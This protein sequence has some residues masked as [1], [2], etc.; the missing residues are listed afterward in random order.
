MSDET[1]V[2]IRRPGRIL[3]HDPQDEG[4]PLAVTVV[5]AV[6]RAIGGSLL[7]AMVVALVGWYLAD[8]GAHGQATGALRIGADGWLLGHG[9]T[10]SAG[11]VPLGI[12]P[13]GLAALILAF[14]HR[15][16]RRA[17]STLSYVPDDRR[18]GSALAA[19]VAAYVMAAIVI[20]LV[21]SRGDADVNI[22]QAILGSAIVCVLGV[23]SGVAVGSGRALQW[24]ESVPGHVR[25]VLRGAATG[26]LLLVVAGAVLV[27]VSL[28]VS[29]N[30]TANVFTDLDLSFG[31]ALMVLLAAATLVP[32]AALLGV[33]YLAGPGFAVGTGTT[34]TASTVTLGPL[35]AFP[36]LAALP[37]DGTPPAW[38]ACVYAVPIVCAAVGAG[39][40]QA[41]YAVPAWDSAALRGFASG[42]CGAL[43]V[44]ILIG[45]A[46]GPMGTGRMAHIGAPLGQTL[47]VLVGGMGIG[48]L[49]GGLV[50]AFVQ[51]RRARR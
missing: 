29:F 46:G 50:M 32:N 26:A 35:P 16:G 41:H 12:T 47:V 51:R 21:A 14:G 43:G 15:C 6:A 1:T 33:A 23:G 8:A 17:G 3:L 2:L 31:N 9:A 45:F 13:I 10:V 25:A 49:L 5:V 37:S 34:V 39:L 11:G 42:V 48:G 40:A 22:G 38:L 27:A 24:W 36:L 18:L 44:W 7:V 28:A 4:R 19:G 20:A 30:Q